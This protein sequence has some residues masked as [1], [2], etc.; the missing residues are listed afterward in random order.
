M[1]KQIS[2]KTRIFNILTF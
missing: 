1:Y 2:A